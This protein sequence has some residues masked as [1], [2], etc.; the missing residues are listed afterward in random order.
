MASEKTPFGSPVE[1]EINGELDLHTFRPSELAPLLKDYIDEC[2]GRGILSLRI[3]HGKGRGVQRERVHH[4]LGKSPFVTSFRLAPP[5]A[6]GWGATLVELKPLA[7]NP[8]F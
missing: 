5:E 3:I 2:R 6:G 8:V 4:L 7:G 1:L